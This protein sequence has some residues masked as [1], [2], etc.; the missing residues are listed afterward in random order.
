MSIL[1]V[2]ATGATGRLLVK[3]LLNHG[4]TVKVIVRS[5]ES[6]PASIS[7]HERLFI[8]Q[9]SLL[10]MTDSELQAHVQGCQAVASCLGHNLTFKG[11]FGHPR[12]LVTDS[13]K[14]LCQAIEKSKPAQPVKYILMN[15]T[16]NQNK[17][18]GEKS[19]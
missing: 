6:L 11:I 2:G 1:V 17:Q 9:A 13:A 16:G 8:T 18:A 14:R 19:R 4:E 15:T 10:D 7:Q 5:R 3:K 12:R